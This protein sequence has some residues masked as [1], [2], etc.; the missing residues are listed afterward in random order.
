MK[1]YEEVWLEKEFKKSPYFS[2]GHVSQ[3]NVIELYKEIGQDVYQ[4][5]IEH[6][7]YLA[8]DHF[9]SKYVFPA[10]ELSFTDFLTMAK[11]KTADE[12]ELDIARKNSL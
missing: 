4:E 6:I 7:F 9:G 8:C 3:E 2:R 11:L 5:I 1:D 10:E 12:F